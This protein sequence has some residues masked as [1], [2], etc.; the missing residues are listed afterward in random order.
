MTGPAPIEVETLEAIDDSD[1]ESLFAVFAVVRDLVVGRTKQEKAFARVTLADETA[2]VKGVAWH[3]A[4]HGRAIP[5]LEAIGKGAVVKLLC[6][7]DVYDGAL[8]LR[9][10]KVRAATSEEVDARRESL[11]GAFHAIVAEVGCRTLVFDI[12]TVPAVER[13]A[14]PSTVAEKLAKH[15]ENSKLEP[16]A[17]MG[18]SPLFGKVVSLAFAD[19]DPRADGAVHALV[20]PPDGFAGTLPDWM[21]AVSE[22]D[23]LRAF[24][25]LA[26]SAEVVVSFNGR[27]F[28]VPFLVGRSLVHRIPVRVDLLGNRFSLRPHLDLYRVLTNGERSLGPG[29]LDVVCWAL[30]IESP[31]NDM[32]GAMV[33][34]AYERGE[35]E[36]IATY[37]AADVRA[38]TELYQRLE[39]DVLRFRQ[40]W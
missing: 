25:A 10:V 22:P 1:R 38:T 3:D 11:F 13:R 33:A 19:G 2:T 17:V 37:N 39:R 5:A 12:E 29:G 30:G 31:K 28:D 18:M 15:A 24:W 34:P 14:L 35:I 4:D 40:D 26:G 8:Q 23:L 6:Q 7:A 36:R 16:D 9:I 32:D 20:V 21:R 27:G